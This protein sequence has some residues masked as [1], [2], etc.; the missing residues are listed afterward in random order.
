[1]TKIRKIETIDGNESFSA[2]RSERIPEDF[3]IDEDKTIGR[4]NTSIS[5]KYRTGFKQSE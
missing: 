3:L 5:V 4:V 2:T 1:M